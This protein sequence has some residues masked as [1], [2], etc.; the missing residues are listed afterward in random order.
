MS[1]ALKKPVYGSINVPLALFWSKPSEDAV[2]KNSSNQAALHTAVWSEDLSTDERLWLV[3]KVDTTALY[4]ERLL[5]L[6]RQGEWLKVVAVSQPTNQNS[7]GYPGWVLASQ[8]GCDSTYLREQVSLTEAVIM[9]PKAS[10][11]SD[12]ALTDARI[13]LSYQTRLPI[14]AESASS[15]KVRLPDGTTGYLSPKE[16]KKTDELS[17]SS[18]GIVQEARRF[19]DLKYLWSGTSSFGFDCSGL[20]FRLY[21]SQGIIIPRDA[22]EQAAAGMAIAKGNLE[23]GDLLFFAINRSPEKIHHVG[24]YI[25][26]SLMIHAPNSKS[27]IRIEPFEGDVYGEEYWGARRYR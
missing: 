21:Q 23:P 20:M 10:L 27:V 6:E 13:V 7:Q 14:I 11:F 24:M 2:C 18:R 8:I 25:G 19:L 4:G 12:P 26:D 5:I 1:D 3:G 9:I 22:S 15:V 17:F 16:I